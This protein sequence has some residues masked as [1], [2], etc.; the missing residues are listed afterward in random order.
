MHSF[1][2]HL[3][4]R[5]FTH[6]IRVWV[7]KSLFMLDTELLATK[8]CWRPQALMWQMVETL[9]IDFEVCFLGMRL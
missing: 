8:Q 9:L 6:I 5:F 1:T 7:K 3:V 2:K 4:S